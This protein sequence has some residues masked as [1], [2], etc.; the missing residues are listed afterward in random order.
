M[1]AK[2]RFSLRFPVGMN[3][4]AGMDG[5]VY[6]RGNIYA[7]DGVFNGTV[8]ATDGEFSGAIKAA[9]LDGKLVGS[10]NAS[11]DLSN[12][13]YID[14]GGMVLD[15]RPGSTGITFRPGYEPIKYQFSTT[16]TGPW[17]D[18][19]Q[20]NDK[21]RRDSLDGGTTWGSAYQ[22]RGSDGSDARVP[23]YIQS[24]YIDATKV[25]SF[26]IRGNK[27][28]AV[29]P[30]GATG[31]GDFGFMLTGPFED[32][33]LNYLQIYAFGGLP[34]TTVFTSKNSCYATWD[35][36]QTRFSNRVYFEGP[37]SFNGEVS[38]IHVT[39]A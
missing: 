18:T 24:T 27:I 21:Y 34:P 16:A 39:L 23:A 12:V 14:L 37:V 3:F 22:F 9:T 31:G 26:Q 6:V 36:T 30:P 1:R 8:Y 25:E 15:G 17:H 33:Q 11:V 28:E 2:N 10:A 38:G 35:F 5:Q 32:E 4:W 19:M 20:T 7:T 29:C 13:D